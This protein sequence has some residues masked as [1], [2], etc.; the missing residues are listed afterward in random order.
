MIR[1]FRKVSDTLYRGSAPSISDLLLLKKMG[2]KKIVSLDE[3]AGKRIDRATKLLGMKHVM[4]PIDINKKSTLIRF[5]QQDM[6]KL[7]DIGGPTFTHCEQGRDRTGLAIAIYR[8]EE[9]GWS[10]KKALKEAKSLGFGIGVNPKVIKLYDRVI[11]TVCG[12]KDNDTNSAYDIV[13]NER[14]IPYGNYTLGPD[15]QQS[16]SPIADYR[17]REY[18]YAKTQV[19]WPEQFTSRIDYDLDDT[20]PDS[21]R[22]SDMEFPQAGQRDAMTDGIGGAGFSNVSGG[23]M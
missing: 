19:D 13:S 4:L 10:C 7:F 22:D 21:S 1:R 5:L 9:Q 17:V 14:D 11:K 6:R 8:C 3:I 2:I 15:E 12:C 20:T 16:W 18:P 23:F